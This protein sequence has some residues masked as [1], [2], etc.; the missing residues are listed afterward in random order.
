MAITVVIMVADRDMLCA[1][2]MLH[3]LTASTIC[4]CAVWMDVMLQQ[5]IFMEMLIIV[6]TI[7]EMGVITISCVQWKDVWH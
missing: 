1:H 7:M 5:F 4:P 6:D 3:R 2:S